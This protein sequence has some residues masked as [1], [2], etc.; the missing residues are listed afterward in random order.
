MK[1]LGLLLVSIALLHGDEGM[2]TFNQFPSATVQAKYGFS[3]TQQWLDHVRLASVRLAEGCSASF[4]SP[5]GLV[6]T[7]YHCAVTC[8]Q[9]ISSAAKDYTATGFLANSPAEEQKCPG[10]EA[11]VLIGISDVTEQ[12]R[13]KIGGKSDQEALA[14]RRAEIARIEKECATSDS[15]R[16]DVVTLYGG[17]VYDLYKYKRY[18]DVRLVFAPEFATAFFGGDPDNFMFPRYDLDASFIRVY[19]NGHPL[20]TKDYFAL[21]KTGVKSGDLTFVSGNPGGTNRQ[22]T[23]DMLELDRDFI[24]PETLFYLSELRGILTEFQTR[25]EEQRRITQDELVFVENSLKAYK[26]EY[27]SLLEK[28]FFAQ[29]VAEEQDFR[30]RV[31]ADPKLKQEYAGL[32]DEIARAGRKARQLWVPYRYLEVGYGF[33]SDLFMHAKRLLRMA[34]EYAKP[35]GER[36]PQYADARKPEMQQAALSA[37][38]IYPELEIEKLTWSLAKL[39]E[40]LG[41]D[42]PEVKRIF[43]PR[44]PREI[45]TEAVK[46]TKL[47]DVA[48]RKALMEGGKA[49]VGAS[50]DPMIALAKVVD[51]IARKVRKQWEDE[52]QSAQT[53]AL[54]KLGAARFAVYG[55]SLYP[56][57][58]FTLRLSYGSVKGFVENGKEVPPFTTMGGAFDR[59]TGRDPF[60][61]APSWLKAKAKLNLATPFN[62]ATT[63]DIIG[64]NSGSPV[65][66]KNGELVGLIF[67]GNIHSLGGNYGFDE[68]LNRAVAVDVRAILEALGKIYGAERVLGELK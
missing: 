61:L 50:A 23:I 52:V 44:S 54:E 63:N 8:I 40:A 42:D 26:G 5:N 65:I 3:P 39:R 35:N 66:N 34:E 27:R 2:W 12:I 64:G 6:L 29:K 51:P 24:K 55:T 28:P 45:A 56:D 11:N 17:G 15:L 68:A 16:C 21:S 58:T 14:A 53:R 59:A 10:Q 57:A 48:A 13:Q 19:D 7:N 20:Q 38:P 18:Q 41:P 46:G 4:V 37:A 60:A 22:D 30:K 49:A 43:G 9:Q 33:Q 67:D 47:A 36:L 31:N 25:G 62:L 32:W 1:R